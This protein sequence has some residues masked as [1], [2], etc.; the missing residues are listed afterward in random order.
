MKNQ[1][2]IHGTGKQTRIALVE[3]GELAQLFIEA[4]ENQRTVG[5]IYMAE[6]HKV[7]SGIRAA[8]ISMGTPK[9]AFLHFSDVGDNLEHYIKLLNGNDAVDKAVAFNKDLNKRYNNNSKEPEGVSAGVEKQMRAGEVLQPGQKMLVQIVKEPIGSKGPRVSTD[10]TIAGRFVV[11]IP[12]GDYVAV[13]KRIRSFKER[14]RLRNIVANRLPDGF[15]IIVRTVAQSQPE[16]SLLEDVDDVLVK[17]EKIQA[18]LK[19]AKPPQLLYRDLDMAESLIRDL[20]AK[21]YNQMLIDDPKIFK[22]VQ[23]SVAKWAP[24]MVPNIK[25]YK[26]KEHIF[27]YMHVSADVESVF[28]PRVKMPSGGYLIFEQTEA[29]YVVDVNSGRYAAKRLQEENSL[30]TNLEAAREI[31]KQLRLRD[32]GGIIVVD[33]IDL[34]DDVNRKKVYDELKKEFRKDKAKTNVLAMSDFGLVQI[35]RQRI[36]PSVVNSVSKVCPMCGG[37]GELVSQNTVIADIEAWL[38]KFKHSY[39]KRAVDI[40]LNPYLRSFMTKGLVSERLKWMFK[41]G[42]KIAI[43]GDETISMNDYRFTL[44]GSDVDITET[45]M[46]DRPLELALKASEEELLRLTSES[47]MDRSKLDVF[48]KKERY[49]KPGSKYRDLD[50]DESDDDSDSKPQRKIISSSREKYFKKDEEETKSEAPVK[51]TIKEK[52]EK[53]ANADS[54]TNQQF[55]TADQLKDEKPKYKD[56]LEVAKEYAAKHNISVKVVDDEEDDY[57]NDDS[58]SH[59]SDYSSDDHSN[60]NDSD[61]NDS[62]NNYLHDEEELEDDDED[63]DEEEDED[64]EDLEEEDDD[65]DSDDEEE[66]SY[67]YEDSEE[68]DESDDDDEDSDENENE[69]EDSEPVLPAKKV[70]TEAKPKVISKKVIEKAEPKEDSKTVEP[71]EVSVK[72]SI[73]FVETEDDEHIELEIYKETIEVLEKTVVENNSEQSEPE[74]TVETEELEEVVELEDSTEEIES[75]DESND[76]KAAPKKK[77]GRK[78]IKVAKKTVEMET[79]KQ[80]M[81]DS[82]HVVV[83]VDE[84]NSEVVSSKKAV[85]RKTPK[86]SEKKE[87]NLPEESIEA[88]TEVV[89]E[90]IVEI[91]VETEV[92][93]V[94]KMRVSTSK[95]SKLKSAKSDENED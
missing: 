73:Q 71:E 30:K 22:E 68:D 86:K 56:A 69:D 19:T 92:K 43:M 1:I 72:S 70:V 18:Q 95:S 11:L 59:D 85:V 37:T 16:K 32:I 20:F 62:S 48:D 5:D 3:N 4:P 51:R 63:M 60:N 90:E 7:M 36:R 83:E 15:G 2:I 34:K 31:A 40:Y 35:T 93:E 46:Q 75:S 82:S 88:P 64:Y 84:E 39:K 76:V 91:A 65:E 38:S 6:V 87:S 94:P 77:R 21:D 74:A 50:D 49:S 45:V 79:P 78:P 41:Y 33:F 25:L 57:E 13:S 58:S 81:A 54:D 80:I 27:D 29:M 24:E 61:S 17:W 52:K 9:D 12:M 44:P 10:I 26:G 42:M 8:F 28:S 47:K 89:S 53:K 67:E 23:A 55:V 66:D 14:R